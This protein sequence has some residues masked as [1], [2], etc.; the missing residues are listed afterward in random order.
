VTVPAAPLSHVA[1][2]ARHDLDPEVG[3]AR[4]EALMHELVGAG[5]ADRG[6]AMVREHLATGGKRLRARLAL[7]ATTALGGMPAHA[8]IWA[9]AVE[10]L[11]NATLVHDDIEDGDRFRRGQPTLWAKHGT[12]QAI[13][14]G[15][16]M[17]MLP[18]LA[19]ARLPSALAAELTAALAS[20]AVAT[21]RGQMAELDLLGHERLDWASYRSA[22]AGKTGALVALPV[23]GAAIIAGHPSGEELADVFAELGVLFQLQDDVLDL[24]GDKGRERPASDLFEGK[25]SALVVAHLERRP[26]DRGWLLELL[27]APREATPA[28][29]VR[30]AIAAV[31][32]SGALAATLA[33]I[34]ELASRA[35]QSPLLAEVPPLRR[36]ALELLELALRPIEPARRIRVPAP[37]PRVA[38]VE[39]I[40]EEKRSR[41]A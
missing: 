11:H 19:L 30:R 36:V 9:A 39:E 16:L 31:I 1:Q 10:L 6:A 41:S 38:A 25:V 14:A 33:R 28:R 21:V 4:A 5:E 12:A 20:A 32:D 23:R 34:D 8:V 37:R 22:I 15:D 2:V 24:Y 35:R 3:L 13:N 18:Y 26:R 17:L 27:R 29:E 7:R 40:A